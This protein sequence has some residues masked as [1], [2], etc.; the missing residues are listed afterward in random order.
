MT[1]IEDRT[2]ASDLTEAADAF[3]MT[4]AK[5]EGALSADGLRESGAFYRSHPLLNF[6]YFAFV[7]GIT[8]F[9]SHPIYL[10]VSFVLSWC[11]SVLLRGRQALSFNLFVLVPMI[12]LMTFFNTLNVHNGETVLFYLN[13]NRITLE[14]I[15]YGVVSAIMLSSVIIWFSCFNTIVTADKFIYLFGRISPALALTL[16]MIMRYIP[17]LKNRF[18]EVATAQRCMG[19]GLKGSS[20]ITRI[21]QFF[22][23]ISILIAWS[24]EASIESADSMEARGYGLRGRTSFHLFRFSTGEKKLLALMLILGGVVSAACAMG[25]MSIYYYPK[26]ILPVFSPMQAGVFIAYSALMLIPIILDIKGMKEW[27][28]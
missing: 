24:L 7:I 25:E 4:A 13:D 9:S 3:T 21:R 5:P 8:M 26:I 14:A 20:W 11:Y 16:S 2:G 28:K 1:D 6:T 19:R 10:L 27:N 22:K 23:E 12:L 17:L 18:R 15:V